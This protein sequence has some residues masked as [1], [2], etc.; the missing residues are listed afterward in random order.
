MCLG[1]ERVKT[2]RHFMTEADKVPGPLPRLGSKP[3][4]SRLVSYRTR[5][6]QGSFPSTETSI[7]FG[8]ESDGAKAGAGAGRPQIKSGNVQSPAVR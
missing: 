1:H 6:L 7:F 2:F 4:N 3:A 5:A 8:V